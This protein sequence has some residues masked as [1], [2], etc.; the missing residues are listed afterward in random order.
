MAAEAASPMFRTVADRE[1]V[2]PALWLTWAS[3]T[4][5]GALGGSATLTGTD[6]EQLLAVADSSS[7]GS[8]QAPKWYVPGLGGAVTSNDRLLLADAP[9]LGTGTVPTGGSSRLMVSSVDRKKRSVVAADVPL[10]AFRTVADTVIVAKATGP[11]SSTD[12]DATTR[13]GVSAGASPAPEQPPSIAPTSAANHAG[14]TRRS[15]RIVHGCGRSRRLSSVITMVL[16]P[17]NAVG[18]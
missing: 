10:P 13:S 18:P 15:A 12:A 8:A 4:R 6:G 2:A 17:D 3:T 11:P 7:T 14:A 16:E 1:N 5:F 9:S